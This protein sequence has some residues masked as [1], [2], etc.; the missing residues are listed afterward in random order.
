MSARG[1][2]E[3]NDPIVESLAESLLACPPSGQPLFP[4]HKH[5]CRLPSWQTIRGITVIALSAAASRKR[6]AKA[7][8]PDAKRLTPPQVARHLQISPESVISLIRSGQLRAIDIAKLGS[9]RPRFR[10]AIEDLASFEARRAVAV[11]MRQPLLP[12]QRQEQNV[13]QFY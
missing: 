1:Y 3:T 5:F 8:P 7:I 4:L 11:P 10:I 6:P 9:R 12:R 13:K 2:S